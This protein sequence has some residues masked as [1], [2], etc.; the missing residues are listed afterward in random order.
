MVSSGSDGANRSDAASCSSRFGAASREFSDVV[1]VFACNDY[2]VP[3]F[4]AA[5]QSLIEHASP[6]RRYDIVLLANDLSEKHVAQL[7]SQTARKGFDIHLHVMDV[8]QAFEGINLPTHGHFRREMYYRLIAPEQLSRVSKAIYMDSDIIIL[9]D[10][11]ELFDIDVSGYLL[12]ATRDA[13]TI[14]Q[15]DGYNQTVRKY[16]LEDVGIDDINDYF[17]S[18][19]LLMNL[20]EFRRSYTSEEMLRLAASRHWHWPDQDVL[21]RLARGRCL[22]IDMAWN[23]LSDW[24][25]K[26]RK[27]IVAQAPASVQAE[28]NAARR[29]PFIVHYAGPDDRPWLYP[30]MDMGQYFWEYA[31]RCPLYDELQERLEASRT[32]LKGRAKRFQ[33]EMLYEFWM[34]LFD[35][36]FKPGSYVRVGAIHVISIFS[37]HILLF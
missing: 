9:R 1:V 21:N 4:S 18:G 35:F 12:A 2:F 29:N 30:E 33:V 7:C 32:T 16:L 8:S 37:G 25:H 26:R 14:G 19:V 31:R 34:P 5:L 6:N 10:I 15:A 11:A 3:Y 28:Y 13:D 27:L 36:L 17:Q 24:R 20:E 23:T 22:T